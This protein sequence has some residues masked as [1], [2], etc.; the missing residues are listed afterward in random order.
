[1]EILFKARSG[2]RWVE[3][4]YGYDGQH[5]IQQPNGDDYLVSKSTVCQFTGLRIKGTKLFQGDIF[6][7]SKHEGYLLPNFTAEVVWIDEYA[8]FGYRIIGCDEWFSELPI[9]FSGHDE[10]R[11]DVL[12]WCEIIGSVHD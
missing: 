9:C 8:C 4:T 10:L 3:G 2:K 12:N 11:S 6:K 7:Y 1:M 5:W